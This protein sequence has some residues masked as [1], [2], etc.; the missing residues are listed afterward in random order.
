M[1]SE[2]IVLVVLARLTPATF[3]G[4]TWINGSCGS[5]GCSIFAQSLLNLCS[6][7]ALPFARLGRAFRV[8]SLD[9][10]AIMAIVTFVRD[11]VAECGEILPHL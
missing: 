8:R 9:G 2:P 4:D 5:L 11:A 7:F 10:R 6:T 1:W 3:L